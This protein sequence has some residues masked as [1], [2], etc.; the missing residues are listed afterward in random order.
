MILEVD[1]AERA[2]RLVAEDPAVR[3]GQ[4]NRET[5][6]DIRLA[7]DFDL[8]AVVLDD[9]LYDPSGERLRG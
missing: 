4:E 2:Q 1:D 3:E 8:A 6:S 7:H 5:G 9:A